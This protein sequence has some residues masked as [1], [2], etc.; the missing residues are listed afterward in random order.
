MSFGD[1]FVAGAPLC[2]LGIAMTGFFQV[3]VHQEQSEAIDYFK[4]RYLEIASSLRSFMPFG[5]LCPL[6]L[7]MSN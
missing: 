1:C 2:P 6:G 3:Q 5:Y 4:I 7:A